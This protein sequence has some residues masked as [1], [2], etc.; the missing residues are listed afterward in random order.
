MQPAQSQ[1]SRTAAGRARRRGQKPRRQPRP[2]PVDLDALS[3]HWRVALNAAQDALVAARLSLSARELRERHHQLENERT[4]TAQLIEAIAAEEHVSLIHHLGAPRP[5]HR[6]LGL[7]AG[8]LVCVF[9]LEGVLT[10]SA[11]IH[12]AAWTD[13]FEPFLLRRSDRAGERYGPCRSFNPRA[14]YRAYLHGR[15][16]LDG[17]RAFLAARGIRLPEGDPNDAPG[18][19]T[20]HGLANR[21]QQAL[22]RRLDSEGV[23]AYEGSRRYLGAARDAGLRCVVVSA[24]A[25]AYAILERA[26]LTPL[27]DGRL[28]GNTIVASGLRASPHPDVLLAACRQL[29]V[30]PRQAAVFETEPAGATAGHAAGFARVVG[31]DRAGQPNLLRDNGADI[32]VTDLAELLDPS[33]V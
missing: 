26:G 19:E 17:V 1:S 6:M 31:V 10:A 8:V 22:L 20:V 15:P 2:A 29:G 24:S 4:T 23:T 7:P 18:S 13:A 30:Q 16:R 14:D 3:A 32:V 11:E 27:V 12:A 33:V 25:N 21:K 28:D 9:D 5:S